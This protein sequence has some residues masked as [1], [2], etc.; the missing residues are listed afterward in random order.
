MLFTLNEATESPSLML[1]KAKDLR[2]FHSKCVD[3]TTSIVMKVTKLYHVC[4]EINNHSYFRGW[5]EKVKDHETR[6]FSPVPFKS[7]Q[8]FKKDPSPPLPPPPSKETLISFGLSVSSYSN[9]N[10]EG[11][12]L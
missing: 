2:L 9:G 5:A 10:F 11:T 12:D 4:V 7:E 1:C 8:T 3:K 6:M